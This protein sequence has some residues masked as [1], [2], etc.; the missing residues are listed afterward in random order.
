MFL[1]IF[2]SQNCTEHGRYF[3]KKIVMFFPFFLLNPLK[4]CEKIVIIYCNVL[5]AY[6]APSGRGGTILRRGGTLC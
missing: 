3:S 1:Q 4:N 2:S 6:G 5:F